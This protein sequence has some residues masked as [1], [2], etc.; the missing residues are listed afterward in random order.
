MVLTKHSLKAGYISCMREDQ[1]LIQQDF[2][3]ISSYILD[4][5]KS[6]KLSEPSLQQL[7]STIDYALEAN[8][9]FYH[10]WNTFP[11]KYTNDIEMGWGI[12]CYKGAVWVHAAPID[13]VV[14][15]QGLKNKRLVGA[16]KE[17]IE[18][19]ICSMGDSA[20][21]RKLNKLFFKLL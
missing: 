21:H 11:K 13:K 14:S 16:S 19:V 1:T 15:E 3:N 2:D 4:I 9:V 6:Y 8:K 18:H 20:L 12:L 5:F 7:L 17:E 10:E